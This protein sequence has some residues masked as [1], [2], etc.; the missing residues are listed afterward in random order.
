MKKLLLCGLSLISFMGTVLCAVP[1]QP[2]IFDDLAY[3]VHTLETLDY[4]KLA[5]AELILSP[6]RKNCF[7]SDMITR[8]YFYESHSGYNKMMEFMDSKGIPVCSPTIL[9]YQLAAVPAK[10][11]NNIL[12]DNS[13]ND[14]VMET[15]VREFLSSH[16]EFWA[17]IDTTNSLDNSLIGRS[18][19]IRR[20]G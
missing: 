1:K 7:G 14:A 13:D 17:T 4:D 6:D 10:I 18:T 2:I 11:K 9:A 12:G 3:T 8:F 20:F 5:K 16:S 19:S 15:F